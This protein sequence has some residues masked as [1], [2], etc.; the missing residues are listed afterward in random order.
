MW[1]SVA[2]CICYLI[3]SSALAVLGTWS[4]WYARLGAPVIEE[5]AKAAYIFWLFRKAQVGFM[6]DAAICGFAAGAGFALVENVAD[7]H[8]LGGTSLAVWTLR[9]FGTA[10]MHGGTTALVGVSANYA[11]SMGRT[12]RIAAFIPG[13]TLAI[14]IHCAWNMAVLTPLEASIS[15]LLGLPVVFTIVFIRSEKSLRKW[16]GDK[17]DQD[18]E[19]LSMI[20]TGRFLETNAGL[21]LRRLSDLLPPPIVGDMLCLLQ[22]SLEL[23]LRAK[24]DMIRREA[25]FPVEPDPS[26]DAHFRE[27]RFLEKSIGIAGR[28]ALDPLLPLGYRDLWELQLLN[29]RAR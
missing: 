1:G 22:L 13:L 8:L 23:S 21:Y 26:L 25:G 29:E 16:M 4:L 18:I 15:V 17:L 28:H 14:L 27:L 11:V 2:A 6:V 9:G 19:V 7:L 3:N 12:G 10:M 24:G 20:S 5:I